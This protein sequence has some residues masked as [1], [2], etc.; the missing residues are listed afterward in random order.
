MRVENERRSYD[1]DNWTGRELTYYHF[2]VDGVPFFIKGHRG[3]WGLFCEDPKRFADVTHAG[4]DGY[5]NHWLR[6]SDAKAYAVE[7]VK[8]LS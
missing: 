3:D 7:W 4:W 5:F 1:V 2:T 8:S 6:Q